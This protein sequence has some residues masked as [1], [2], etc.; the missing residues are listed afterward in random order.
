MDKIGNVTIRKRSNGKYEYRFEIEPVDGK[1]RWKTKGG[2]VRKKEAQ[3]AGNKARADYIRSGGKP[4]RKQDNISVNTLAD[5]YLEKIESKREP[6]TYATYETMLRNHIRPAIGKMAV[7]QV[8]YFDI[9]K[10]LQDMA[11]H[12]YSKSTLE[13][14]KAILS[15]MFEYAR[16]PMQLIKHNPAKDADIPDVRKEKKERIPYTAEQVEEIMKQVPPGHDYRLP[17]VLG[18]HCGLRIGEALGLTWDCVDLK[19]GTVTIKK[20]LKTVSRDHHTYQALK[21]LKSKSSSRTIHISQFVV[22][23]LLAE[24]KRQA[25]AAAKYGPYY[26]LNQLQTLDL[27]HGKSLDYVVD[28]CPPIVGAKEVHLVCRQENG[29]SIRQET[30]GNLTRNISSELGYRVDTHTGRHTHATLIAESGGTITSVASRLGHSSFATTQQ[31]VHGTD[32]ADIDA[33]ERFEDALSTIK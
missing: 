25:A 2:F 31:Y 1:R 20:Q 16:K 17:L 18:I 4:E 14:V 32:H 29:R 12:S 11:D 27:G 10:M 15:G 26:Y 13:T 24:K 33:M 7:K 21:K 5:I 6:T 19:S 30:L 8:D 9:E 22:R 23:E 3:E 28:A